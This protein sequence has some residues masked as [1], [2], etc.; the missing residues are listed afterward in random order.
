MFSGLRVRHQ[1][2]ARFGECQTRNCTVWFPTKQSMIRALRDPFIQRT[3]PALWIDYRTIF[4]LHKTS[5]TP[6]PAPP[7]PAITCPGLASLLE[8]CRKTGERLGLRPRHGHIPSA[9]LVRT[10]YKHAYLPG[11][12]KHEEPEQLGGEE[13]CF[14]ASKLLLRAVTP[15][16]AGQITR[17]MLEGDVSQLRGPT[18]RELK[19]ARVEDFLR[20]SLGIDSGAEELGGEVELNKSQADITEEKS[21]SNEDKEA[22]FKEDFVAKAEYEVENEEDLGREEE[23][24]PENMGQK[25]ERFDSGLGMQEREDEI[26]SSKTEV[27]PSIQKRK[28]KQALLAKYMLSEVLELKGKI[29]ICE[30]KEVH[31]DKKI[32]EESK[33]EEEIKIEEECKIEEKSKMEEE[34][35]TEEESQIEEESKI[36][37]EN[38]IEEESNRN[39]EAEVP[40]D[41]QEM[42]DQVVA[43][44]ESQTVT[45]TEVRDEV[46]EVAATK[47]DLEVSKVVLEVSKVI[48]SSLDKEGEIK[49]LEVVEQS[50]DTL[51]KLPPLPAP[52]LTLLVTPCPSSP[53]DQLQEEVTEDF[54]WFDCPGLLVSQ[55]EGRLEV[56]VADTELGLAAMAGLKHKYSIEVKPEVS[57]GVLTADLHALSQ[58]SLCPD[59]A[60]GLFTLTFRDRLAKRYKATMEH[61]SQYCGQGEHLLLGRGAARQEVLVSFPT[62]EA[63]VRALRDTEGG[64]EF[65]ELQVTQ[66]CRS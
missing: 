9:K 25:I 6:A 4:I 55:V 52:A 36:E 15:S 63:A 64:Q 27:H 16:E 54:A 59:P 23:A 40:E 31:E 19:M 45:P 28:A 7:S 5:L 35:K 43:S 18:L 53:L 8:Q 51:S 60:S 32:E 66:A 56:A 61:F 17:A 12:E 11:G 65:P 21:V 10:G 49:L 30:A 26:D 13:K 29:S 41:G 48:K 57:R 39:E 62:R 44:E 47:E 20:G 37:E 34:S 38:K 24:S 1:H 42:E 3:Y 14:L 46:V 2:F 33:I 50:N 58:V 22:A